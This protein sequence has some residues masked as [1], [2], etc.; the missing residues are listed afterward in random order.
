MSALFLHFFPG[1]V[2][3]HTYLCRS[4]H[5]YFESTIKLNAQLLIALVLVDSF[6]ATA[7]TTKNSKIARAFESKF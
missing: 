6:K 4:G 2:Q 1:I 3:I 7:G 5:R